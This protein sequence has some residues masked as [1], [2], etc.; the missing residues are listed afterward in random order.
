LLGG[1]PRQALLRFECAPAGQLAGEG[2]GGSGGGHGGGSALWS[3]RSLTEPSTCNYKL[4]IS[5]PLV[6][7]HPEMA[8]AQVGPAAVESAAIECW[9]QGESEGETGP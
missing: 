1:R 9:P 3:L 2:S 7:D 4:A 6:C 8:P 5:T